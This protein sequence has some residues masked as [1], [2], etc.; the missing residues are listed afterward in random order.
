MD[1]WKY[2]SVA[3]QDHRILNPMSPIK[4]DEM[5]EVL[6]LPPGSRVLDIACGKAEMLARLATRYQIDGTGVDFSPFFAAEAV[7]AVADRVRPPSRVEIIHGD[8]REYA[9]SEPFDLAM[10]IGAS[11]VYGGHAGTLRKLGEFARPGGL[12]LTG[13]PFWRA[14]PPAEYLAAAQ[15]TEDDFLSHAGN[16]AVGEDLGMLPLYS[17]EG[18]IDDWDRYE[19]LRVQ[20]A[21]R[22]AHDHPEDPD[23]P[24][25]QRIC[26]LARD[27][28]LRWGRDVLGWALYLFLKP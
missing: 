23:G 5:I 25:I 2:Y 26:R 6:K 19:W 18:A 27:N 11:W 12:V 8:G 4:L 1:R 14:K 16:V 20:A 9:S 10:C 17:I 21:E 22:Y 3:H 13:E 15:E 7:R 28:Y 24:E